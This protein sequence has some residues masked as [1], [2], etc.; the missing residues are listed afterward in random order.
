MEE[1]RQRPHHVDDTAELFADF[2]D[3]GDGSQLARFDLAPGKLPLQ[4]QVFVHRALGEQD[5]PC[6]LDQGADDGDGGWSG[7]GVLLNKEL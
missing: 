7:Q 1:G 2:P 4:R 5:G 6:A 3:H